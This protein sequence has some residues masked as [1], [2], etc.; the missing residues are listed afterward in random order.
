MKQYSMF[1]SDGGGIMLQHPDCPD[2]LSDG[3]NVTQALKRMW[4]VEK[5]LGIEH[6]QDQL[7][8]MA[9][10]ERTA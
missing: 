10:I 4:M 6:L 7:L 5:E 1:R 2:A 8:P 3:M 9:L